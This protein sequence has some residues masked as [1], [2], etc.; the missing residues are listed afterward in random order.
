MKLVIVTFGR[1]V[2]QSVSCSVRKCVIVW[3][4]ARTIVVS[5]FIVLELYSLVHL[6]CEPAEAPFS[7]CD[8]FEHTA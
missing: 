3:S 5:L 2:G 6:C 1:L 8:V 7:P 4:G